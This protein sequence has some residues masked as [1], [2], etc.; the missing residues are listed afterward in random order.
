MAAS[1]SSSATVVRPLNPLGALGLGLCVFVSGASVMIYEFVAVRFLQRD[2]GG[3]IDV[4]GAVI[5][6]C[7]LGL[8]IGY[9]LGGWAADRFGT[10]RA[11][12]VALL[13]GG[14]TGFPMEHFALRAGEAL[15][16]TERGLAWHPYVAAAVSSFLPI[17][18]L[19]A[20]LPQAVRLYARRLDRVGST[21]GWIAAL[22][23]GGSIGGVLLATMVLLTRVGTRE[24]LYGTAATLLVTGA[25]LL[26]FG[27]RTAVAMAAVILLAPAPASA[28]ILYDDYS[29]YHHILVQDINGQRI[30][31]FDNDVQST[32][33][34]ADP[35]SGAFEYTDFFHIPYVFNPQMKSVLFLGLGGGSGP[36]SFLRHY[37]NVKVEVA[38]IDPVVVEV[39]RKYFALPADPRLQ[40]VVRDGRVHLQRGRGNY[41]A[42]VVDAYASGPYGAYIPYSLATREFFRRAWTRLNHGGTIVYNVIGVH[43]GAYSDTVRDIRTTMGAVFQAVYAFQARSSLNTVLVGVKLDPAAD[44]KVTT[45]WPN[46]PWFP[47]PLGSVQ[48]QKMVRTLIGSG[49]AL[50]P[51]LDGRVT[52]FSTVHALPFRGRVLTDN[53]APV[54]LAPPRR[55]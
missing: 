32:M 42:I 35:Y 36:K 15:L 33:S 55:R 11:L 37:P 22:S 54:D 24:T 29:A 27:R 51:G 8:A 43:G 26:P 23:T 10:P 44:G 13:F 28:R 7:M 5:S 3:T 6:V 20:V 2:F 48:L 21:T 17:L 18:S 40:I 14:A 49:Q 52:Q 25:A 19:G 47:H 1:T 53:Y 16:Q 45:S 12:G 41:D 50:P 46:G 38:E 34:L 31:R 4:W 30:L 39:A 9:A